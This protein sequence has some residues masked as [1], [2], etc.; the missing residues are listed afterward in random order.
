MVRKFAIAPA[1]ASLIDNSSR[2][3]ANIG[4][5]LPTT[6]AEELIGVEWG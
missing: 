3:R 5:A 6:A 2:S 4:I 1:K